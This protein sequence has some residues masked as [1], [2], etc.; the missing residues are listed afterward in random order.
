[1]I[2]GRDG[3]VKWSTHTH[4]R[5]ARFELDKD[6]RLVLRSASNRMLFHT[7]ATSSPLPVRSGTDRLARGLGLT[8]GDELRRGTVRLVM[9]M[10]GNLVLTRAGKTLWSTHTRG[11]AGAFSRVRADGNLL[12]STPHGQILWSSRTAGPRVAALSIR[13][14]GTV[15]MLGPNHRVIWRTRARP[16]QPNR[17]Q[18]VA[19]TPRTERDVRYHGPNCTAVCRS[20]R[21]PSGDASSWLGA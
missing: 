2:R 5:R 8:P 12:V 4:G 19:V 14:N 6:G 13:P 15:A 16:H 17:G 7:V 20:N 1:V 18:P 9:Q 10:D 21:G 3:R 11:H